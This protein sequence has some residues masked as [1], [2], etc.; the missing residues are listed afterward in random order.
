ML[1]SGIING[2]DAGYAPFGWYYVM[3]AFPTEIMDSRGTMSIPHCMEKFGV[4]IEIGW[5]MKL[6]VDEINKN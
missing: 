5:G 3:E 2:D 6:F 4:L 1:A